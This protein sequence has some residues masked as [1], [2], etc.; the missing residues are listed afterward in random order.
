MRIDPC[1]DF[2]APFPRELSTGLEAAA[3]LTRSAS[4]SFICCFDF[5]GVLLLTSS[6]EMRVF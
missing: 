4:P 3:R 5:H 1:E 2:S 6:S